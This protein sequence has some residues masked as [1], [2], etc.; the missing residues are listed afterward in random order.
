MRQNKITDPRVHRDTK[1]VDVTSLQKACR[2][3]TDAALDYQTKIANEVF[4]VQASDPMFFERETS[5]DLSQFAVGIDN[6]VVEFDVDSF[7]SDDLEDV[8]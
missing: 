6:D 7:A 3:E 1:E 5:P 4:S 8:G 2:A